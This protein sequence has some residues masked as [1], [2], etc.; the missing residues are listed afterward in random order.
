MF[1]GVFT[2]LFPAY[3]VFLLNPKWNRVAHKLTQVWGKLLFFFS[4]I[5][6]K[7]HWEFNFDPESTYI[8]CPNHFSYADIP[9]MAASTP[10]FFKFVGK[11]SLEKI[12]FF[13]HM[14]KKLYI[15]VDRNSMM[16][17]Y[18]ALT[19]CLEAL[20]QEINLVIFPE[21]GI[22]AED[23]PRLTKFKDGPFRMAIEKGIPI[24]PVTI[25]FNWIFLQDTKIDLKGLPLKITYHNPI[26]TKGM[27]LEDLKGL[28]EK[29][30]MV[31]QEALDRENQNNDRQGNRK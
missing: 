16:D 5:R 15:L 18:K 3:Y 20:D 21:G 6:V 8:F 24:V 22:Y 17:S 29:T 12:P 31:I 1:T 25:P 30:K 4:G 23:P 19:S 2:L 10:G 13:G 28:K 11:R 9:L 27:K 26:E 14:Y 7:R